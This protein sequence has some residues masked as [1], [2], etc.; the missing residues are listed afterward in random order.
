MRTGN[1]SQWSAKKQ[2]GS[3]AEIVA[4][5]ATRKPIG[6]RLRA[7]VLMRFG[8]EGSEEYTH[9]R[10]VYSNYIKPALEEI[11]Y[12]CTRADE[13][14]HSGA[15]LSDILDM[16]FHADI[17]V[18][19]LTTSNPNVF[20]ELAIRQLARPE[21]TILIRDQKRVPD[22]VLPFD[23]AGLRIHAYEG[24]AAKAP[25][26]KAVLHEAVAAIRSGS[27]PRSDNQI[28][29]PFHR[30]IQTWAGLPKG[31]EMSPAATA[32]A[33]MTPWQVVLKAEEDADEDR[34]PKRIISRAHDV[35]K[36]RTSILGA[37]DPEITADFVACVKEFFQT[38]VFEPSPSEFVEMHWLANRLD[39]RLV[40]NA[41][42][43]E[44]LRK[45]PKNRRLVARRLDRLSHS[46]KPEVLEAA[47]NELTT[48]LKL[49]P[50]SVDASHAKDRF[51]LLGLLLDVYDRQGEHQQALR[52]VSELKKGQAAP[53]PFIL[54][55]Y[56][57]ALERSKE[58]TTEQIIEAYREAVLHPDQDDVAAK[59]LARFMR[60]RNRL[61]DSLELT[62]LA[63]LRDAEYGEYFSLLAYD[64]SAV[65]RPK[66]VFSRIQ[67]TRHLPAGLMIEKEHVIKA[68]LMGRSCENF[69]VADQ[70][71]CELAMKRADIDFNEIEEHIQKESRQDYA[72]YEREDYAAELHAK[73]QSA[74]T[75]E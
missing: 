37:A 5:P 6:E 66:R 72:Q 28:Y 36:R 52:I 26:L 39:M 53:P 20:Y 41:I 57:R 24:S 15:I 62:T 3:S 30:F 68:I 70:D 25:A 23:I 54:R 10:S 12:D 55:N 73:L 18:V 44:G 51:D 50:G 69:D 63:C 17:C 45:Y 64:L 42:L 58:S 47:K 21:G 13:L 16:V 40:A 56:A 65:L 14:L 27:G 2:G 31:A 19:D 33:S 29:E 9:F 67:V 7:C 43:D 49:K 8:A 71:L 35:A 34:V 74:L 32:S 4:T 59:W 75:T 61:V 1:T 22:S 11:G 46:D 38:S 48:E 60:D